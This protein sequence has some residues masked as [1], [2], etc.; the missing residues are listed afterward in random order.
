MQRQMI[1]SVGVR[2]LLH[3]L[4]LRY[5]NVKIVKGNLT[6]AQQQTI[7]QPIS[8]KV[9]LVRFRNESLAGQDTLSG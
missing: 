3:L 6:C 1:T 4:S 2:S 8:H 5:G 7:S 9:V